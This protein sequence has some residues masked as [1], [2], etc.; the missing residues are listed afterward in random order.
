MLRNPFDFARRN[1]LIL[2]D[3]NARAG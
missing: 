3:G 2:G 1:T